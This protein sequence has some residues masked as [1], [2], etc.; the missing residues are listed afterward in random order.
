MLL[1]PFSGY[2]K[3]VLKFQTQTKYTCV[4]TSEFWIEMT[5]KQHEYIGNQSDILQIF[6]L[7]K[8]YKCLT[9]PRFFFRKR[10]VHF[11]RGNLFSLLKLLL[12]SSNKKDSLW[13]WSYHVCCHKQSTW[14][15]H[16]IIYHFKLIRWTSQIL[17]AIIKKL[18][19]RGKGTARE[20]ETKTT[21]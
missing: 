17:A 15:W 8:E 5:F 11:W 14:F 1:L 18:V 6:P 2:V 13:I 19:H 21:D 10:C 20:N 4:V 3:Q 12:E 16:I 9:L 7:W